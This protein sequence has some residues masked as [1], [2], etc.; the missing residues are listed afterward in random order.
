[1]S[2]TTTPHKAGLDLAEFRMS[3][4][5]VILGL[6][7]VCTSM[8]AA[9]LYGFG[10]LVIP[11]QEAFGWTRGELQASITFLFA[12]VAIASQLL[13]WMYARF[14]LRRV[15]IISILLQ[16]ASYAA[17]TQ[18]NGNIGWLYFAFFI[19]PLLCAGT[20]AITWTQLISLWYERNRGLALAIIL[21]GTG[22]AALIVPPLLAWSIEAGGWQAGF[23]LLAV[24]PLVITLPMTLLWLRIPSA[25]RAEQAT[26]TAGTN[27]LAGMRFA[28]ARRSRIFWICNLSLILSVSLI[29]AMVTV[30]V[31]YLQDKGVPALTASQ[32][33]S[34]FGASIIVGRLLVG[35]LL[36]HYPP[37]IISATALLTPAIGCFILLATGPESTALL[38]LATVCIGVS[39]G[40][41]FDI[42]AFLMARYFGMRDYARIFGLHLGL[43]TIVAGLAPAFFGYIHS[44]YGNYDPVIAYSLVAAVIA[45]VTLL[46]L[47]SAAAYRPASWQGEMT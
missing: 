4:R 13:G 18:L 25:P 45:S 34:T 39:A 41:E 11:L 30:M 44:V 16:V 37:I 28:E 27:P 47:R 19:M 26:A 32:I 29:V 8:S 35:Y 17:L 6:F 43:V 33:F 1:M 5:V 23:V 42:A 10:T 21:S 7:G 40:A 31:P 15:A 20:I 12:G 22:V 38:V 3:W 2:D 46:T 24:M 14:G 36:D 9:L